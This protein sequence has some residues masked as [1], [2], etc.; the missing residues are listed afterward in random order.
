MVRIHN[1][2]AGDNQ[3]VL[4]YNGIPR[5]PAGRWS[6]LGHALAGS[7]CSVNG[8]DDVAAATGHRG[9][10]QHVALVLVDGQARA[11]RAR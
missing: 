4:T 11:N 7:M 3:C 1:N 2:V 6:A 9:D 8:R 10:A 5:G